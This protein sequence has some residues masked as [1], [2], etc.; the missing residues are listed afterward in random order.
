MQA[1]N[2]GHK[3]GGRIADSWWP[4]RRRQHRVV[5]EFAQ[6][7]LS[8]RRLLCSVSREVS[9]TWKDGQVHWCWGY[10]AGAAQIYL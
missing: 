6:L 7:G 9:A 3:R 2:A 8:D 1:G 10:F 5:I 4:N